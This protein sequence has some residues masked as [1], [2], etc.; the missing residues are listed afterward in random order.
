MS[1][2]NKEFIEYQREKFI[3]DGLLN[4]IN[5][6]QNEEEIHTRFGSTDRKAYT[7]KTTC[8]YLDDIYETRV[9][10]EPFMSQKETKEILNRVLEESKYKLAEMIYQKNFKN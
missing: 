3:R 5:V 9:V 2:K 1:L 6:K 7:V 10:I 8:S 4:S